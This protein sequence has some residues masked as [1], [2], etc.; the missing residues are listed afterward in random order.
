[1]TEVGDNA[2]GQ[3]LGRVKDPQGIIWWMVEQV[4]TVPEEEIW[5]R[6]QQPR[7]T[8]NMREAQE[9]LDAEL[10]GSAAGQ[11]SAPTRDSAPI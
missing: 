1:M 8:E 6:L 10:S 7:Y 4:E 9:S 5:Q 11:S 2:F 3:C